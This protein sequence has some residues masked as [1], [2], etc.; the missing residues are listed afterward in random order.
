MNATAQLGEERAVSVRRYAE[1]TGLHLMTA[2]EHVWRG[3]VQAKQYLGRWL[4]FLP[5]EKEQPASHEA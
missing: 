4:I 5:K 2:Y 1:M 3:K